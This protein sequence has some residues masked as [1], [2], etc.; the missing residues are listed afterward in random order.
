MTKEVEKIFDK[1]RRCQFTKTV[2]EKPHVLRVVEDFSIPA[3][4]LLDHLLSLPELQEEAHAPL[5]TC[6]LGGCYECSINS[7]TRLIRAALQRELGQDDRIHLRK[8]DDE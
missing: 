8:E 4:A 7:N 1:F 5:E 2:G 6:K 3:Q